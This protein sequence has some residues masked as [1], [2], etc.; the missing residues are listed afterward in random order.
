MSHLTPAHPGYHHLSSRLAR[1]FLP[2]LSAATLIFFFSNLASIPVCISRD[3]LSNLFKICIWKNPFLISSSLIIK[4][5]FS[6]WP[7]FHPPAQHH[8][9]LCFFLLSALSRWRAFACAAAFVRTSFPPLFVWWI[10]PH[11]SLLGT[12]FIQV[13]LFSFRAL[14]SFKII[15]LSV[16]DWFGSLPH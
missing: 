12:G 6:T 8:L 3:C 11:S 13:R 7:G 15:Y 4:A 9:R 2:N 14:T 10:P 5:K 16:T 1:G